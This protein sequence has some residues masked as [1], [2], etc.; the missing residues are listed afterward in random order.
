[1]RGLCHTLTL[2]LSL[3]ERER[4]GAQEIHGF[5]GEYGLPA[6]VSQRPPL[7]DFSQGAWSGGDC[8]EPLA[9]RRPR[10]FSCRHPGQGSPRACFQ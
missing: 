9:Q 5:V 2:A 4:R 6:R 10:R 1:M 3:R 8:E 7:G